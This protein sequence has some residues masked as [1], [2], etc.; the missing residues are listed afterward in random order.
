M[1]PPAHQSTLLIKNLEAVSAEQFT[2]VTA[3]S[4]LM[5]ILTEKARAWTYL[6][7]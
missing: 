2:D 5:S 7:T 3:S 4:F 1:M 6:H